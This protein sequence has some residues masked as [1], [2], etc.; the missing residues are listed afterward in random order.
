MTILIKLVKNI[1][2][3]FSI[4]FLFNRGVVSNADTPKLKT[5]CFAGYLYYD[6]KG[7]PYG[8]CIPVINKKTNRLIKCKDYFEWHPK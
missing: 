4:F 8:M 6:W 3:Y 2:I 5:R 7:R 1:L